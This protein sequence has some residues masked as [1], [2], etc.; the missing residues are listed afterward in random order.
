[1][2]KSEVR[3]EGW[4]SRDPGHRAWRRYQKENECTL[5]GCSTQNTQ[6]R[7]STKSMGKKPQYPGEKTQTGN[8]REGD[9]D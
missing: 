8:Q 7:R 9:G 4:Q 1:M 5:L 6:H 3:V 2:K